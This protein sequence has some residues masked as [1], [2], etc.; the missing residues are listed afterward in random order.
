MMSAMKSFLK[1]F[2]RDTRGSIIIVAAF[3]TTGLIA[4]GGSAYDFG[5]QQMA[6]KNAQLAADI[7]A[8][9]AN[10]SRLSEP[11]GRGSNDPAIK[12]DQK[13]YQEDLTRMYFDINSRSFDIDPNFALTHVEVREEGEVFR[14]F[15]TGRGKIPSRFVRLVGVEEL[16]YNIETV[17][18]LRNPGERPVYDMVM[19]LDFTTSMKRQFGSTTRI[20]ALQNASTFLNN[21]IMCGNESGE[22][23]LDVDENKNRLGVINYDLQAVG[24][25]PCDLAV[26][27]PQRPESCKCI[28]PRGDAYEGTQTDWENNNQYGYSHGPDGGVVGPGIHGMEDQACRLDKCSW[29]DQ[30]GRP[31]SDPY[32]EVFHCDCFDRNNPND[33]WDIPPAPDTPVTGSGC[34]QPPHPGA[35]AIADGAYPEKLKSCEWLNFCTDGGCCPPKCKASASAPAVAGACGT[36]ASGT[37]SCAECQME[38]V[39]D[40]CG[41]ARPTGEITCTN[42]HGP[43]PEDDTPS[44]PLDDT[45]CS[46]ELGETPPQTYACHHQSCTCSCT[47]NGGPSSNPPCSAGPDPDSCPVS[48][49]PIPFPPGGRP[50][51][52]SNGTTPQAQFANAVGIDER[53]LFSAVLNPAEHGGRVLKVVDGVRTSH[54]LMKCKDNVAEGGN[55]LCK[56]NAQTA[57]EGEP[58]GLDTNSFSAFEAFEAHQ[59]Y[60]RFM[61]PSQ[62]DPDDKSVNVVVWVSDGENNAFQ[63]PYPATGTTPPII[64]PMEEAIDVNGNG[65]YE[66]AMGDRRQDAGTEQ[67]PGP[68]R[69]EVRNNCY[70]SVGKFKMRE[71][72]AIDGPCPA[73]HRTA[74][75]WS[76]YHTL[77]RCKRYRDG[78]WA[79]NEDGTPRKITIFSIYVHDGSDPD[80]LA[81]TR[82]LMS[83]CSYGAP[84][85][86]ENAIAPDQQKLFFA[87][88][89]VSQLNQ[90]F[91]YIAN[92]LGRIR[93][94]D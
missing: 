32:S 79:S 57:I 25:D 74:Q 94:V 54:S 44:N 58:T 50:N 65:S 78:E 69:E 23:C 35:M 42:D 18:N 24:L 84:V 17:I 70:D 27:D 67:N 19:L 88:Q 3:A 29:I 87:V 92:A 49:T 59:S 81:H 36:Y 8:T 26:G 55:I 48:T 76:D 33:E 2:T 5:M 38:N 47:A 10:G 30:Q 6:Y 71:G 9:S 1:R 37:Y 62:E 28:R 93:I 72:G 41:C 21:M 60:L 51:F 40:K 43:G 91:R 73:G 66:P 7:G 68:D 39:P 20:N 11:W 63:Y 64:I 13:E 61:R 90:A 15:V 22:N 89:N 83:T 80:A 56:E 75:E 85:A 82:E 4:V 46:Y 86:D 12:Q 45:G 31:A 16:P 52:G 34:V 53:N 14:T 77:E